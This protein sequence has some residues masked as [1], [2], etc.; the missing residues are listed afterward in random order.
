MMQRRFV[1]AA[2]A[3]V[4][5]ALPLP[6]TAQTKGNPD[7]SSDRSETYQYLNLFGDVLER[8]FDPP[9]EGL[10]HVRFQVTQMD[11]DGTG[12]G[13]VIVHEVEVRGPPAP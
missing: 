8:V 1:F 5:L 11:A 3:A 7:K 4:A 12:P 2:L 9:L 13:W 10:R 6:A